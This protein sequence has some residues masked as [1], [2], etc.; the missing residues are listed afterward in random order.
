MEYQTN[1]SEVV[2][3][4]RTAAQK[5]PTIHFIDDEGST[6]LFLGYSV[7]AVRL[8][9]QLKQHHIKVDR[10]HPVLVYL[11][12]GV[13]GSPSGVTFGLKTIIGP[14]IH[15]VFCEPTHVPSVTLDD[16]RT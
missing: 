5:D 11:P 8:Q 16:D 3:I 9:E 13:G 12:A 6:D 14:Y 7:A 2:S 4:A 15:A 1:F 10:T